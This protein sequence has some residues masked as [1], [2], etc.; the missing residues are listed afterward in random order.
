[1]SGKADL[2]HSC[3]TKQKKM[4]RRMIFVRNNRIA[5]R[6]GINEGNSEKK[7]KTDRYIKRVKKD[8]KKPMLTEMELMFYT[9][10]RLRRRLVF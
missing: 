6:G 1:M 7:K 3:S 9:S 4:V 8:K 5:A 10:G 2:K